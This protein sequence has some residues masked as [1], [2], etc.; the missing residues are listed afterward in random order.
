M[1]YLVNENILRRARSEPIEQVAQFSYRVVYEP[2]EE[3]GY[4]ARVPAF[5]GAATQGET[6]AEARRMAKDLIRGHIEAL[7]KLGRPIPRDTKAGNGDAVTVALNVLMYE[8][9]APVAHA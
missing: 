1:A 4:V 6:L 3:G 5:N 9:Q 8:P 7:L 2:A